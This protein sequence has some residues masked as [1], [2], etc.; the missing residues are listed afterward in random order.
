M[1]TWVLL[2]FTL[3]YYTCSSLEGSNVIQESR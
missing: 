1:W 2:V 3:G